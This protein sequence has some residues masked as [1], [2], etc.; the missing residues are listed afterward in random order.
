MFAGVR[1]ASRQP[2]SIH[3]SRRYARTRTRTITLRSD[4]GSMPLVLMVARA[5]RAP[6]H[7]NGCGPVIYKDC[8]SLVFVFASVR[9][10][11]TGE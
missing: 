7:S 1:K 8:A 2:N 5:A 4:L 6:A 10:E 11:C 3:W 9:A